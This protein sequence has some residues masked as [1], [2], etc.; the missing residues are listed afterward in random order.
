[1]VGGTRVVTKQLTAKDVVITQEVPHDN[2]LDIGCDVLRDKDGT[3]RCLPNDLRADMFYS[4]GNCMTPVAVGEE[5][6]GKRKYIVVSDTPGACD[7]KW[8][9]YEA[10]P[11][12]DAGTIPLHYKMNG[13]MDFVGSAASGVFPLGNEV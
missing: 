4:D 13:C 12:G 5:D 9:V 11:R 8:K 1:A 10:G 7:A 2:M 6:C 3:K